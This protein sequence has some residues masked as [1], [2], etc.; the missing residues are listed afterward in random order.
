MLDFWQAVTV[1]PLARNALIAGLLA[2]VACGVVGA[3][4]VTRR[5]TYIAAGVAHCV[6][7]GLGAAQYLNVVHGWWWLQPVHGA[8]VAAI[9]AAG[10]IG[11]VAMRAREREDTAIGAVWS[12]GMAL[13][14]LFIY[15]TP[16]YNQDMMSY[17]FGNI[18]LVTSRDLWNTFLLDVIIVGL[19]ATFHQQLQA[20]CFDEEFARLR[21]LRVD[22][23]Y[24]VLLMLTAVTV[25]VLSMVVGIV[26]VIALLTLP[27]AIAGRFAGS[28][29]G[30]MAGACVLCA[31]FT[32]LGLTLSY[33]P[34][35]PA[36]PVIILVCG[37]AYLLVNAA[38][39][40]RSP[41]R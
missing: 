20:V 3:Y 13:G 1:S 7:A 29:A 14:I 5:I 32:S 26:L 8:L 27:A 39:Y 37:A 9:L 19:A 21:N 28:L 38:G 33:G 10:I 4:V 34:D 16:G 35:L 24:M 41:R 31:V 36:G 25:V 23:Y 30:M 11:R 17:L 40:W 18:L 6:L 22:T 2:S 15:R 12:V